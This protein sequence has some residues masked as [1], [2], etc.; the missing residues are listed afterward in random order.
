MCVCVCACMQFY[1]NVN[2]SGDQPKI[3]IVYISL[4]SSR[5]AYEE[6]RRCMPWLSLQYNSPLRNRLIKRY[7][8]K[9][10]PSGNT[11]THI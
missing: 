9:I 2:E 3:E 8:L 11:H 10:E 1:K 7:K 4:D 5:E 6:S